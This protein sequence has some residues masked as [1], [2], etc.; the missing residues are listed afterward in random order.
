MINALQTTTPGGHSIRRHLTSNE[1]RGEE[2]F[3]QSLR[4]VKWFLLPLL[5][6]LTLIFVGAVGWAVLVLSQVHVCGEHMWS[7]SGCV[8]VDELG[9]EMRPKD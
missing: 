3:W 9:M 2:K 4:V 8:R 1:K 6:V 7:V 5:L